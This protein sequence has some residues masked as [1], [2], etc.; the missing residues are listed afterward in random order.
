MVV[1]QDGTGLAISHLC[2][3]KRQYELEEWPWKGTD[4][5]VGLAFGHILINRRAE[6][7]N[8]L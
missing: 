5:P 4:I 2:Y 1:V 6:P 7:H 8:L 3:Y